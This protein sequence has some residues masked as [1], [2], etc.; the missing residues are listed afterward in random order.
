[1]TTPT[2]TEVL[3]ERGAQ[4]I[5]LIVEKKHLEKIDMIIQQFPSFNLNRSDVIRFLIDEYDPK[6]MRVN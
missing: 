6:K 3:H 1:M 2:R 5:S 4:H